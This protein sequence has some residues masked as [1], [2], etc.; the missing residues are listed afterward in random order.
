[1][2][3]IFFCE[4]YGGGGFNRHVYQYFQFSEEIASARV[5][6]ANSTCTKELESYGVSAKNYR[7][8]KIFSYGSIHELTKKRGSFWPLIRKLM[9][10]LRPIVLIANI[11]CYRLVLAREDADIVAVFNGGYP[12]SEACLAMAIAGKLSG[13][14]V[15]LSIVSNPMKKQFF[16]GYETLLDTLL[17]ACCDQIVVNGGSIR[18]ELQQTRNAPGGKIRVIRNCLPDIYFTPKKSDIFTVGVLCRLDKD[19]NVALL[20]DSFDQLTHD[21]GRARLVIAGTG[22]EYINLKKQASS[23]KGRAEV[24]FTGKISDEIT[25]AK[26]LSSFDVFAFP[27]LREGF[28]YRILE[29]MRA[30]CCILSSD[31]G[32]VGEAIR[33]LENGLLAK[34]SCTREFT[35]SLRRLHEDAQLRE[36]LGKQARADFLSHYTEDSMKL[37]VRKLFDLVK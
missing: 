3:A 23:L 36:R 37:N 17:W 27:S 21:F 6:Y 35:D 2:K 24:I 13:K 26:L 34:P 10:I 32:S 9:L 33:D 19:K 4:N 28:P 18:K 30:G 20:L 8:I 12:A 15:L 11:L 1:M 29:A 31:V 14:R 5:I 16:L 25:K 22:D 7:S